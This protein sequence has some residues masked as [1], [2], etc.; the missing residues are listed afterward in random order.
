MRHPAYVAEL[1]RRSDLR[2][3][4]YP[5]RRKRCQSMNI[6][7]EGVEKFLRRSKK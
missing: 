4:M 3:A 6:D 1:L 7:V 5:H 2:C